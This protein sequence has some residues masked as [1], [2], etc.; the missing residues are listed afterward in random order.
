MIRVV[1]TWLVSVW[2]EAAPTGSV[3]GVAAVIN[4]HKG[5]FHPLCAEE[6]DRTADNQP[7]N[8]VTDEGC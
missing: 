2:P 5:V 3:S 7:F 6:I 4:L 1:V 8:T